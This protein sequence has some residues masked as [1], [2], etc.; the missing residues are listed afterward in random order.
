MKLEDH[1]ALDALCG[2][3]LVGTLRGAARRRFERALRDEPRVA[4]RLRHWQ[5]MA[6]RY[7]S[8]IEM[9]PARRVW[10]R[11]ERELGLERYRAPWHRRAG[12]WMAWAAATTIA[13]AI[14]LGVQLVRQ[15]PAVVEIAQL[16]GKDETVRVTAHRS[17]D[18]R[19]LVLKAT[20]PVIASR[21]QSYELW[22]IPAEGGDPISLAV[23]GSLDARFT[24]P[25][26]QA[27]RLRA[28]GT[29]AVSTEPAGGSPTGKPTGPVIL[30]GRVS[31]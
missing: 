2:E 8:M 24:V 20:R 3:Y 23:L 1:A 4:L 31:G 9:Q 29:L 25:A 14:A 30:A 5:S 13:L 21:A 26:A 27:S 7:S 6:P 11:L 12:F 18:G 15:E 22:L 16:A 28:G 19:T 17:P 10:Q